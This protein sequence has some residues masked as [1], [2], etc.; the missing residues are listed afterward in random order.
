MKRVLKWVAGALLALG[1]VIF[2]GGMLM[3]STVEVSRDVVINATPDKIF[4]HIASLEAFN[5]WSPWADLDPD[6]KVVFSGSKEGV[7][8]IMA[9]ESEKDMGSGNMT[10]VESVANEKLVTALDFGQMGT[11]TAQFDLAPDAGGTKVVW[12][13]KSELGDNPISRWFGPMIKSGV[14]EQYEK[15]LA[16]LRVVAEGE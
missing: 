16:K 13:M 2:G 8:Q 6:M 9:W 12:S 3:P 10:V 7:G 1:V 14:G 15:G 11:A 5:K 4:P